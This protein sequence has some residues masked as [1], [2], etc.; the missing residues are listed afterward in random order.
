MAE[1][2]TVLSCFDKLVT[3]LKLDPLAV[4]NELVAESLIP[5]VDGPADAQRLAQLLLERIQ[6]SPKRYYDVIRIFSR[7]KWLEDIVDIL[8]KEQSMYSDSVYG[9]NVYD[10]KYGSYWRCRYRSILYAVRS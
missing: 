10:M 1:Y 6:L 7:H 9:G 5:P 8:Q 4:S 2:K 3:A